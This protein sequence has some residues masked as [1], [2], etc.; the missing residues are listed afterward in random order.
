MR[1]IAFTDMFATIIMLICFS[2]SVIVTV[3]A[4]Y[5]VYLAIW[6]ETYKRFLIDY[7]EAITKAPCL[8]DEP[9]LFNETK[10]SNQSEYCSQ[11]S[12]DFDCI[13]CIETYKGEF[14][15]LV[16]RIKLSDV[17]YCYGTCSGNEEKFTLRFPVSVKRES[18]EIEVGELILKIW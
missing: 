8:V 15:G 17:T 7:A 2:A 4:N 18:G 12:G 6:N 11:T 9:G 1:S 14:N 16:T 13:E 5:E 3:N 10:L